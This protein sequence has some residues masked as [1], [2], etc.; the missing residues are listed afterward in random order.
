MNNMR[1]GTYLDCK[2]FKFHHRT[3]MEMSIIHNY[4]RRN[5]LSKNLQQK[6]L[7]FSLLLYEALV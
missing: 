1:D 4:N 6:L 2:I 7:K 3:S 5:V